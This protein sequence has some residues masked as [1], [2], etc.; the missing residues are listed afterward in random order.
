MPGLA[1]E[2]AYLPRN[3]RNLKEKILKSSVTIIYAPAGYGKTSV[4]TK[5]LT[6]LEERTLWLRDISELDS[7]YIPKAEKLINKYGSDQPA[8]NY[9][10][11][12]FVTRQSVKSATNIISNVKVDSDVYFVIYPD[13]IMKSERD[14]H[15]LISFMSNMNDHIHRILITRDATCLEKMMDIRE[16]ILYIGPSQ[17]AF[18]PEDIME[19]SVQ[20]NNA[21]NESQ[22]KKVY[23]RTGGWPLAVTFGIEHSI[24]L[25]INLQEDNA[26]IDRLIDTIFYSKLSQS[27]KEV[28]M[29]IG[30]FDT[31]TNGQIAFLADLNSISEKAVKLIES[32][33]LIR[34]DKSSGMYYSHPEMNRF[35][36]KRLDNSSPEVQKRVYGKCGEWYKLQNDRRNAIT[37]FWRAK[38]Y[39]KIIELD[40][41]NLIRL[42][43]KNR[44]FPDILR[45]MLKYLDEDT[46]KSH[47]YSMLHIAYII[48]SGGYTNDFL[49]LMKILKKYISIS[50]NTSLLGEWKLIYSLR[51]FPD[52]EK[53][54]TEM[55][56]AEKL[57]NGQSLV[58]RQEEAC[59]FG[60]PSPFYMLYEEP[61][62]AEH[63]LIQ[64]GK[65]TEIMM[66]LCSGRTA[67]IK[68]LLEGEICY[69]KGDLNKAEMLA[70]KA[71]YLAENNHQITVSFGSI[72]LLGMIRIAKSDFDG[73]KT[74]M[75]DIENTALIYGDYENLYMAEYLKDYVRIILHSLSIDVDQI[76]LWYES[77]STDVIGRQPGTL[78]LSYA[79]SVLLI[80]GKKYK[81][82]IGYMYAMLE[83]GTPLV[84]AASRHYLELGI[85]MCNQII[86][87]NQSATEHL[88]K[89]L[90]CSYQDD[91]L[92]TFAKYRKYLNPL[93]QSESIREN[94]AKAIDRIEKF[95][96][97]VELDSKRAFR[98]VSRYDGKEQLSRREMEIANLAASGM[99]NNEISAKLGIS[100]R[101]VKA[102]MSS[103]FQKLNIDRRSKLS[104]IM[105]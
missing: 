10:V 94:Y 45:E 29:M 91:L 6:G 39:E 69:M 79:R 40:L 12:Q 62:S 85:A 105:H 18:Q 17:L 4:V 51:L 37:Y 73:L 65:M 33:P 89:A 46:I 9:E 26:F 42:K 36:R 67:G 35:L 1:S 64:T 97:Y 24:Y 84:T 100:E 47:L 101:T 96:D 8:L 7:G 88:G 93:L 68:E 95:P 34:Y 32:T 86:G 66:R 15:L 72:M 80:E 55:K 23:D 102:H 48:L 14:N 21:M 41:V 2:D 59:L 78:M 30:Q 50:E 11:A 75:N 63:L 27:V 57:I 25:Q 16:D 22:A 19:Y 77:G 103:V 71:S 70:Y 53:M 98:N 44:S 82:A 104:Q 60:C 58:L 31:A 90:E 43:I 28:A 76:A 52:I 49:S 74:E 81:Q 54:I 13:Y 20:K 99:R 38:D 61:G 87:D 83:L 3:I 92:I 5:L 56:E